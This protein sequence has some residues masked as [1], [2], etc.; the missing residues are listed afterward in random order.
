MTNKETPLEELINKSSILNP[1]QIQEWL[2]KHEGAYKQAINLSSCRKWTKWINHNEIPYPCV[3]PRRE[4]ACVFIELYYELDKI[5]K[6]EYDSEFITSD[7]TELVLVTQNK[8]YKK[9]KILIQT[10]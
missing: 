8:P 9:I 2:F 6:Q 3:C 1:K 10:N 4:K 7:T 5:L